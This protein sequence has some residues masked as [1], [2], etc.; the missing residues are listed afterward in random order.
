MPYPIRPFTEGMVPV[1][2]TRGEQIA[3]EERQ[4]RGCLRFAREMKALQGSPGYI[5]ALARQAR[6]HAR[7]ARALRQEPPPL[8]EAAGP[9]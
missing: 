7:L 9:S 5:S 6:R 4:A 2:L 3:H 1:P 8:G